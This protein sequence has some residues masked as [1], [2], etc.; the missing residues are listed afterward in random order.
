MSKRNLFLLFSV[1]VASAILARVQAQRLPLYRNPL[2]VPEL[3]RLEMALAEAGICCE[4]DEERAMILVADEDGHR[5]RAALME[6]GLPLLIGLQLALEEEELGRTAAE[7]RANQKRVQARV[8]TDSLRAVTAIDD[9]RVQ[10]E[11]P[12]KCPPTSPPL[13]KG[14]VFLRLKPGKTLS[15]VQLRAMQ[16]MVALS[17]PALSPRQVMIINDKLE[18]LTP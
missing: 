16:N 17:V 18:D 13:T 15:Q 11:H 6:R 2:H 1:L 8:L 4:V 7:R 9:A 10:V 14:R 12:S 5:A 3:G